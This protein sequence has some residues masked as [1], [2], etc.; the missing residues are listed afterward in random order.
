M[1]HEPL[2]P[3]ILTDVADIS[4]LSGHASLVHF[5]VKFIVTM[6]CMVEN[7]GLQ[8]NKVISQT[9]GLSHLDQLSCRP[10][11]KLPDKTLSHM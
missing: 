1:K 2:I 3:R 5:A 11:L 8:R 6:G 9:I 4:S 10:T 7:K